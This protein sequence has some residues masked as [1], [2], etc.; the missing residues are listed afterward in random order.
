[1]RAKGE[2]REKVIRDFQE[3]ILFEEGTKSVISKLANTVV[4]LGFI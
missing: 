3:L 2:A 4:E 1:M